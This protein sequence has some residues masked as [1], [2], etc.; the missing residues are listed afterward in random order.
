M[1]P[2]NMIEAHKA[3]DKTYAIA[4]ASAAPPKE[5]KN[6]GLVYEKKKF[7]INLLTPLRK[8][9]ETENEETIADLD[10]DI[11]ETIK[12]IGDFL[13]HREIPRDAPFIKGFCDEVPQINIWEKTYIPIKLF[14]S[15]GLIGHIFVQETTYADCFGK[16][17]ANYIETIKEYIPLYI[18]S[19]SN[20]TEACFN[21]EIGGFQL[22]RF[23]EEHFQT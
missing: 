3:K 11:S 19:Y 22:I 23:S 17:V 21:H 7:F 16:K 13:F 18:R 4:I 5:N 2:R 15:Q 1:L 14:A 9:R 20:R 12:Q 10:S 8:E 6:K